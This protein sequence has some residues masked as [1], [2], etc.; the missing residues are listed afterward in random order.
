MDS[1]DSLRRKHPRLG[2]ESGVKEGEAHE[3]GGLLT[4][5]GWPAPNPFK[6]VTTDRQAKTQL[7]WAEQ[8]EGKLERVWELSV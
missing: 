2:F 7:S 8:A 5:Q 3:E 1:S 6:K 4:A